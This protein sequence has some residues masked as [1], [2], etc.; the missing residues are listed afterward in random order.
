MRIF[1]AV[2][3]VKI[4]RK[5]FFVHQPLHTLQGVRTMNEEMSFGYRLSLQNFKARGNVEERR[6]STKI[7]S[8]TF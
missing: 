3:S 7:I 6:E 1:S 5:P 8:F 2:S 4:V